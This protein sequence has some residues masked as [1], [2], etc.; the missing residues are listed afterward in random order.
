MSRTRRFEVECRQLAEDSSGAVAADVP[1]LLACLSVR[2]A[3]GKGIGKSNIC[4]RSDRIVAEG[5]H[6]SDVRELR[7]SVS[8]VSLLNMVES[9]YARSTLSVVLL[10]SHLECSPCFKLA[11]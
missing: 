3:K 5:I 11:Y 1:R 10:P 4:S 8:F 9:E 6:D 7:N 2:I